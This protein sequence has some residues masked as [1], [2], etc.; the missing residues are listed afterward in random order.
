MIM[1]NFDVRVIIL[2]WEELL[3]L[4]VGRRVIGGEWEG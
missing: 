3:R 1:D 2:M 4:L